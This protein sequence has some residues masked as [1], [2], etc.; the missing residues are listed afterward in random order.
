MKILLPVDGSAYSNR[1]L[2]HLAAHEEMYGTRHEYVA[3]TVVAPI[4]TYATR[5]LERGAHVPSRGHRDHAQA[6]LHQVG[7]EQLADLPV[8]VDDEDVVGGLGRHGGNG[9]GREV[10]A[11]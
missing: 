11:M 7:A 5:F 6:V 4:P 1:M 3:V 8:V 2:A 9:K 10:A